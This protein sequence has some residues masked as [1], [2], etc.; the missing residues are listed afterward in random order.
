M[1][2][3]VDSSALVPVYVTERFSRAARFVVRSVG[4]APFNAIHQLEVPNTF[5]LLVGRNLITRDQCR[6]L[7]AQLREDLENRRLMPVALDLR[8]PVCRS[9]RAVAP[10]YGQVPGS[11][12]RPASRR[13]GTPRPV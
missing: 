9:A 1:T 2:T 5:E 4:Q 13:G 8:A 7:Q 11:Q 12:P 3:Y 10:L 6:S